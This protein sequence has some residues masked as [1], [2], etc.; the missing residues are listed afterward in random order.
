MTL[1]ETEVRVDKG[2]N[3][4]RATTPEN[5]RQ[6]QGPPF[7][8]AQER[9]R[10]S[11]GKQAVGPWDFVLGVLLWITIALAVVLADDGSRAW[12][13]RNLWWELPVV[14]IV[15]AVFF[16]AVLR[17]WLKGRSASAQAAALMLFGY[18]LIGIAAASIFFFLPV[19]WQL[20]TVRSVVL[21]V[22]VITPVVMWWLFL[23]TQRASLLNEFLANLQRLGLLQ[24]KDVHRPHESAAARATRISSYLQKFEAT[25]GRLPPK[26]HHEVLENRF[27][28][29]ST[30]EARAQ[31]S[32]ATAAVPVS[33]TFVLLIIGWLL[34]LPPI[35]GF[36][37]AALEPRWL[38][39]LSPNITP[40]T[41]AFLGAYFFSLQ[42]L[43]RR[44]VRSDLRGSAYV[45]V[46]IRI[47][48]AVIGILVI[49]A[50]GIASGWNR[51]SQL[52]LLGFV[53]GV[54]PMVAWQVIRGATAKA[55][56]LALPSLQSRLPLDRIDGL[57]VWHEA[58]L[59]EEDIENV[60]NMATADIVDLLVNT[61]LPAGRIIDWVDQ[62][63]LLTQL[64]PDEASN[65]SP[66]SAR[67]KLALHGVR[68]AS[69][70]LKTAHDKRAGAES[71]RFG[72]VLTD[73]DG[74]PTVSSLLSA[75]KTNSN[76]PLVLKWRCMAHL[77]D[78]SPQ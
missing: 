39:A 42:M 70:L 31:T 66:Q 23:A 6:E 27:K 65:S 58:R 5:S 37:V 41:A 25:Y 40:A 49:E 32:L 36:P 57:T 24:D 44:Y 73:L 51:E 50:I 43:F 11:S 3:G 72:G 14:G 67:R 21:V 30:A 71:I 10:R 34:V 15:V 56:H 29:Y 20:I 69:A 75:V 19:Q 59:E 22:L 16:G 4:A 52:V 64:G 74:R 45:A 54:F 26:I 7:G 38:L 78:E 76:L 28:P 53:V 18:P 68:T 61:R 48:L 46:V 60:P 13:S 62:A 55:F 47:V 12:M 8:G 35:D 2:S 1:H 77:L 63:M 33:L 9:A 17:G